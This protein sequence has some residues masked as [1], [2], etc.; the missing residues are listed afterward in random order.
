M[1]ELWAEPRKVLGGASLIPKFAAAE[2]CDRKKPITNG[3]LASR[4]G[5]RGAQRFDAEP[6]VNWLT[7]SAAAPWDSVAESTA[8]SAEATK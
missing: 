6:S 4:S 2:A 8:A 5:R 3:G 7:S 1:P